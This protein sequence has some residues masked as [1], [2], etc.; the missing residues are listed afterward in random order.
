MQPLAHANGLDVHLVADEDGVID[1]AVLVVRGDGEPGAF[2]AVVFEADAHG[3]LLDQAC[4][5]L[6]H[7][8]ELVAFDVEQLNHGAVLDG[9]LEDLLAFLFVL[10]LLQLSGLLELGQV[11]QVCHGAEAAGLLLRSLG[12]FLLVL[13]L[14]HVAVHGPDLKEAICHAGLHGEKE[15]GVACIQIQVYACTCV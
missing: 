12:D 7:G 6:V 14:C 8:E 10:L 9:R 11:D 3:G 15:A 13:L 1:T 4:E 5:A 2:V